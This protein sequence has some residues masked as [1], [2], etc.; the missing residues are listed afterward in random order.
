LREEGQ[1]P[2]VSA[3]LDVLRGRCPR[4]GAAVATARLLWAS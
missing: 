1:P 4:A 2:A 3:N